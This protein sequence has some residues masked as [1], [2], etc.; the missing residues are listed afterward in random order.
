MG[1]GADD[2]VID[3]AQ[4]LRLMTASVR[5]RLLPRRQQRSNVFMLC[6]LETSSEGRLVGGSGGDA[7]A[8]AGF[9][10]EAFFRMVRRREREAATYRVSLS[11]LRGSNRCG[12]HDGRG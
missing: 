6:L 2:G 8:S 7:G 4:W 10:F 1:G 5:V 9:S 12:L 11:A 3:A